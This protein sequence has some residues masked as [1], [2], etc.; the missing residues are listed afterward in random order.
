MP[1]RTFSGVEALANR[2]DSAGQGRGSRA[3]LRDQ[4]S[5]TL[6]AAATKKEAAAAAAEKKKKKSEDLQPKTIKAISLAPTNQNAN[7]K[8]S[9][10]ESSEC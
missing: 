1:F 4:S 9:D 8:T 5:G 3:A 6:A 2:T 10:S 7:A